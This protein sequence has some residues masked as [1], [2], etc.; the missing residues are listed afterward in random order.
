MEKLK[1]KQNGITLIALVITI[2][3]LL[4]LA[5]I[6]I[7]TLSG[8]NGILNKANLAGEETKKKNYEE[9]LKLISHGLR[10]DKITNNWDA[11][12]YLDEFEN[13]I[14]KNETFNESEINRR[15]D[16]SIYV[17]TKEEYVYKITENDIKFNGI[18]DETE[19]PDLQSSNVTF[20]VSPETLTNQDV[21]VEIV[22]ELKDFELE[23]SIDGTTW[24]TYYERIIMTENGA[25]YARLVNSTGISGGVATKNITNIDKLPPTVTFVA[26]VDGMASTHFT[27]A[28]NVTWTA[29]INDEQSQYTRKGIEAFWWEILRES[30]N[31]WI[32]AGGSS[33]SNASI[34]KL[35]SNY[36]ET[37]DFGLGHTPGT[38]RFCIFLSD[39]AGNASTYY[40]EPVT[41]SDAELNVTT[42]IKGYNLDI[43][44]SLPEDIKSSIKSLSLNGTLVNGSHGTFTVSKKGTYPLTVT[45]SNGYKMNYSVDVPNFEETNVFEYMTE[46]G[47]AI[48]DWFTPSTNGGEHYIFNVGCLQTGNGGGYMN[49][50]ANFDVPYEKLNC[51]NMNNSQISIQLVSDWGNSTWPSMYGNITVTYKDGTSETSNTFRRN[52]GSKGVRWN[53]LVMPLKN[54]EIDSVRFSVWRRRSTYKLELYRNSKYYFAI[55]F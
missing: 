42:N 52:D 30:D 18:Y 14:K 25:I 28:T 35:P 6:T 37:L 32:N 46:N 13:E 44:V 2:I 33:G 45:L 31:T 11:K 48:E 34:G 9:I 55:R 54:N 17:I 41:I 3:I 4:I 7:A 39:R 19:P 23:Y 36:S 40:S 29:T 24:K 10:A 12:R 47:I 22:T 43:S 20:N 51:K 8:D 50:W 38:Y 53:E 49:Y 27:T 26:S 16:T 21:E 15:N 5:G 1:K